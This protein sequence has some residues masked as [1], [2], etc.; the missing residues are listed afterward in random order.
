M[1]SFIWDW[2]VALLIPTCSLL[3]GEYIFEY[4]KNESLV[5]NF[6]GGR[7]GVHVLIRSF[8]EE[9]GGGV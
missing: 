3:G 5:N 2:S 6:K 9:G 1:K 7:R 4:K 8:L